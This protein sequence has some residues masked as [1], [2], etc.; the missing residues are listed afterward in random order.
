MRK[1]FISLILIITACAPPHD[2]ISQTGE[3]PASDFYKYI[4]SVE[5]PDKLDFCG[6]PVP[7]DDPEVRERAEREFYL[8]LQQPGQIMLYLKRSGRYF[9]MFEKHLKEN[10]M[11]EDL[12]YMAVAES[13]LY[14]A[15]SHAGAVGIWQFMK[16]TARLMGLHVSNYVD[17]RRH[18][19]KATIA[20]LKYLKQGYA[21]Q[22]S[23]T[24]SAAGYNMGHGSV[25][26]NL[27]FQSG[28]RYYELYLNPETSRFLFRI[29]I[30]KELMK[31]AEKYG[32]I[33]DP[34]DY[35]KPHDVKTIEWKDD[36]PDLST[37][38]EAHGTTY[39]WVKLLNPWI[40]KKSL[41][42]PLRGDVYEI[43]I[44]ADADSN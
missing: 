24:L 18:P 8:L 6:E 34:E 35:W 13:A 29:V 14:Q 1:I 42:P 41:R 12:R 19:E 30:I 5:L 36:I 44:P 25:S 39:K 10:D 15:I 31:N 4:S 28:D 2:V 21:K 11:P 37:W 40:I 26:K 32:F 9:P 27:E 7:L 23:W 20:A 3:T 38:A 17:E 43:A 33:L 16:G 22:G